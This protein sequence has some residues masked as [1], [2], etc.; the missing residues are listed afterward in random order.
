MRHNSPAANV[1][2]EAVKVTKYIDLLSSPDP[3]RVL[4]AGFAPM[5]WGSASG[6]TLLGLADIA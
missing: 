5:S 3:Q 6:S 2:A 1:F 4:F